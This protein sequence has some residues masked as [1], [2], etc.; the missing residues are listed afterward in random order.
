MADVELIIKVP[1]ELLNKIDDENYQK[2]IEW[3]NTTLYC[4]LKDGTR[5]PK[6]HDR[7]LILSKD[8]VK[9]YQ[10]DLDFSCQK[11]ISEVDLSNATVAIIEANKETDDYYRGAQEEY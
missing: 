5:L 6:E 1:E 8:K 2:V 10:I 7:L 11:W 9:E 3:Y 4:A